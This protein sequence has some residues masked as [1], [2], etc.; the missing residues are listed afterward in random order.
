MQH[1]KER[2]I[3]Q[4]GRKANN[5]SSSSHFWIV[6][7]F[8]YRYENNLPITHSLN[9]ANAHITL[10]RALQPSVHTKLQCQRHHRRERRRVHR[11]V[12]N[13][14]LSKS[15]TLQIL[16]LTEI[17]PSSPL[18]K[19]MLNMGVAVS[20]TKAESVTVTE[21]CPAGLICGMTVQDTLLEVRGTKQ[22]V[23]GV[24]HGCGKASAP[25]DFV[26]HYPVIDPNAAKNNQAVVRYA[27]CTAAN[28]RRDPTGQIPPCPPLPPQALHP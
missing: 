10:R 1:G 26:A 11:L 12:S 18:V 23:P 17:S 3:H 8:L 16:P 14:I 2:Q 19:G 27:S 15:L 20:T 21:V 24:D 5:Q 9:L 6:M 4:S 13:L 22:T 25:Q 28:S 7:H